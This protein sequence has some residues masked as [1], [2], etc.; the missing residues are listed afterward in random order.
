MV[1]VEVYLSHEGQGIIS[2]FFD[3]SNG[4]LHFV[5]ERTGEVYAVDKNKLLSV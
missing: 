5:S 4:F 2:P 3:P 1:K